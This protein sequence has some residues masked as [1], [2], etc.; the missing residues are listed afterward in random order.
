VPAAERGKRPQ[1]G[2]PRHVTVLALGLGPFAS[3][4]GGIIGRLA[5]AQ[6]AMSLGAVAAATA[7]GVLGSKKDDRGR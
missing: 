5:V 4:A 3:T 7:H 6:A 1:P 2:A